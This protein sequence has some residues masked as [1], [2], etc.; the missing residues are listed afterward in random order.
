L[1]QNIEQCLQLNRY[2]HLKQNGHF[3]DHYACI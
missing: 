1:M 3:V 2:N